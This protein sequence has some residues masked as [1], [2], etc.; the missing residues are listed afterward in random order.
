MAFS[1]KEI[2][3][4]VIDLALD[5]ARTDVAQSLDNASNTLTIIT[6]DGG[7]LSFKLNSSDNDLINASD[8]MKIEGTV[9]TEIYWTNTAQVGKTAEIFL[10]WV[11]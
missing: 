2:P 6:L 3:Y 7:S 4:K 8:G 11:D 10:S 1:D 5:G 9:I